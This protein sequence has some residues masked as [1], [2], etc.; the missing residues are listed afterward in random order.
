MGLK[1]EACESDPKSAVYAVIAKIE[2]FAKQ[3]DEQ[4]ECAK[5]AS[6]EFK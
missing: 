6:K 4:I 5:Q 2:S 3:I 1:F